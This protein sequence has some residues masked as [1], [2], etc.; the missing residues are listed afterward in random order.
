MIFLIV[1]TQFP[2]DRLVKAVDEVAGK[3]GFDERIVAQIGDSSYRPENFDAVPSVEKALFDRYFAEADSII[4]HAGMGTITMALDHRK[5]LLVMP[6]L[7]KYGEVVNDHQ[8][9]LAGK[10]EQL[11]YLLVACQAE[12]VPGK[13]EQLK[14]FVPQKRQP[15]AEVVAARISTFL[16]EL[17]QLKN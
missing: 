9:A 4:S 7:K 6:R 2:F 10:F 15:S 12:D 14:S 16:N 1:G 5:P 8:L 11:G 3:N 13:M 17:A